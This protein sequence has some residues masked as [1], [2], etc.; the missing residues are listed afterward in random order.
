MF[1]RDAKYRKSLQSGHSR[2]LEGYGGNKQYLL[3]GKNV[4]YRIY[5]SLYSQIK[6]L[7][8]SVNSILQN[9][10]IRDLYWEGK[11]SHY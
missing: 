2:G 8:L 3:Y 1:A 9:G 5:F 4:D 10:T 7:V 11:S 6:E